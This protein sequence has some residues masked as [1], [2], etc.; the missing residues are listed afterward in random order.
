[1]VQSWKGCVLKGTGGSNPP[2]SAV[3]GKKVFNVCADKGSS[4]EF[5]SYARNVFKPRQIRKEAAVENSFLCRSQPE[6]F[7]GAFFYQIPIR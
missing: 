1:M 2:L 3:P 5:G 7:R 6:L 4:D